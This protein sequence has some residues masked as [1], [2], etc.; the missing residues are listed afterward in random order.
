MS[1]SEI[2]RDLPGGDISP[3]LDTDAEVVSIGVRFM[4]KR[5]LSKPFS[6][7][8]FI[9]GELYMLAFVLAPSHSGE[10]VPVSHQVWRIVSLMPFCGIFGALMGMGIG[11][12]VSAALPPRK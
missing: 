10:I 3:S 11:L 8:G 5:N 4:R 1:N 7:A 12:L 6:I 2:A 9:F